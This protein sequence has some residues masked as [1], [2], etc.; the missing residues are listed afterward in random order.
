MPVAPVLPVAPI[1]PAPATIPLP[2]Q[3]KFEP[4]AYRTLFTTEG[5]PLGILI[6]LATVILPEVEISIFGNHPE[7]VQ[8]N[9][10]PEDI[11]PV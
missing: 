3:N 2:F 5:M 6:P 9:T 4:L 10:F 8:L 11:P 7:L 1:D